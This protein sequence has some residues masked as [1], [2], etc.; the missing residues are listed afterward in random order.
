VED[1]V[2]DEQ[3]ELAVGLCGHCADKHRDPEVLGRVV[4]IGGARINWHG[5]DR[6][7]RFVREM[8]R[9]AAEVPDATDVDWR[10]RN[11]T[12][13]D[14][15]VYGF[16]GPPEEIDVWCRYDG[17]GRVATSDVVGKRGR[18]LLYFK[19]AA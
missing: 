11:A 7:R 16:S 6:D 18:I 2:T 19:A 8:R 15:P 9:R 10:M 12:T 3:V 13:L 17:H 4:K 5:T 1:A 14:W